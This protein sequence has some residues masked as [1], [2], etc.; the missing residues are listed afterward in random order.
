MSGKQQNYNIRWQAKIDEQL[1]SLNKFVRN[2]LASQL[3]TL[4]GR[5]WK[6]IFTLL[7]ILGG[8]SIT[9]IAALM[10]IVR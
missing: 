7:A 9:L 5:M 4:N 2:D 6:L 1:A 10:K 8:L 3:K